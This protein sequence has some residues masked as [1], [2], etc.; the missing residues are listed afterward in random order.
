MFRLSEFFVGDVELGPHDITVP[1]YFYYFPEVCGTGIAEK[2]ADLLINGFPLS[3]FL[4]GL[5]GSD[6]HEV[7]TSSGLRKTEGS[8][9]VIDQVAAEP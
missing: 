2:V 4:P 9:T 3:L 8:F 6:H 1:M 5:G 7:V